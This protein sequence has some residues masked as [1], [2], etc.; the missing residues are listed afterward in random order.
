MIKT[1]YVGYTDADNNKLTH[2][3]E[4]DTTGYDEEDFMGGPGQEAIE[5]IWRNACPAGEWQWLELPEED[6][7]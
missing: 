1:F 4:F 2:E 6:A 3:I 5:I 7:L